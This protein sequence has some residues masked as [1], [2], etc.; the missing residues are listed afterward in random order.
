MRHHRT[1]NRKKQQGAVL[2][3]LMFA[4]IIGFATLFIATYNNNS[5]Q[6]Q[7]DGE[8]SESLGK[9]KEAVLNYVTANYHLYQ[10]GEYG[11]LPCPDTSAVGGYEDGEEHKNCLNSHINS[12]GHLPWRA[13]GLPPFKDST[14]QCLWYIVT[15]LDKKVS[16]NDIDSGLIRAYSHDR[17]TEISDIANPFVAAIIAPKS[18]LDYQARTGTNQ[19]II[20]EQSF[21]ASDYLDTTILN[22]GGGTVVNNSQLN[23]AIDTADL[24]ITSGKGSEDTV[25]PYSQLNPQPHNDQI[26][27]ITRNELLSAITKAGEVTSPPATEANLDEST[28]QVSF[29]N[30]LG[31]FNIQK[32]NADYTA[33]PSGTDSELTIHKTSN[34][35]PWFQDI[36]L[37]YDDTFELENKTLRT[38]FKLKLQ[39]DT[40]NFSFGRCSG[41][42]FT[43]TPGPSTTCG[44][45]G[46]NL[47]FAGM[48]GPFGN[49]S[50]AVE[51]DIA[52]S[53]TKNDPIGNHI[54]VVTR[55][56]NTHGSAQNPPCPSSGCYV[57]GTST[58][59][60]VTWLEDLKEHST[61]VEIHTGYT[62]NTC[63]DG[64]S[65]NGGDYAKVI[66]WIDC[67][68][69]TCENFGKL[70]SNYNNTGNTQLL[71]Q[72]IDYP[73][74]M[75]GDPDNG[76]NGIR[77]GFTAAIGGCNFGP[78]PT[79]ITFSEFGL[80]IE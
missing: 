58:Q 3:L 64:D 71:S 67:P 54:A 14:G 47:A 50:F 35:F 80:T 48:P 59:D 56:H 19:N 36:C 7:N 28:A 31:S 17:S 38:F 63:I 24:F 39:E 76:G 44:H 1:L 53:I 79:D 75:E 6:I 8:T 51:Y 70:D 34:N 37:W 72:C 46:S 60:D 61:R 20:C 62:S 40:S 2:L 32:G 12:I 66:A 45:G 22:I 74:R 16:S 69:G 52:P 11:F 33:T 65:G 78:I 18:A 55:S 25:P 43:I 10:T 73:S 5:I 4:V 23:G 57:K 21:D 49:R 68:S 30:N 13:L 9:A 41:F 42:T 29:T 26:I 27:Y 15:G 77:F